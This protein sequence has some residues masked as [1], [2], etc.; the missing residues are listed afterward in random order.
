MTIIWQ[1][2]TDG[3]WCDFLNLNLQDKHF[4]DMEGVYI[5]WHSGQNPAV[6]RIGQ[7]KIKDRILSHRNDPMITKYSPYGLYV[8]WAA[9][10]VYDRDGV[11][12]Y[13]GEYLKPKIGTQFPDAPPIQVN[14]PW[15]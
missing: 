13:L 6:V 14:M 7:G 8:T 15:A 2:Y 12:R 9:V 5:I 10:S 11:E 1:K 3:N 4:D